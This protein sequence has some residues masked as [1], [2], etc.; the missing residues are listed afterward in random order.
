MFG[1]YD[2][3]VYIQSVSD[4]LVSTTLILLYSSIGGSLTSVGHVELDAGIMEGKTLEAGAV[5]CVKTVKNPVSLARQVME[6][7]DHV[8]LVAEGAEQFAKSISFAEVENS[9][10][11]SQK[12]LD[13]LERT[14]ARYKTTIQAN[15]SGGFFAD[16]TIGGVCTTGNGE[17]IAKMV[18]AHRISSKMDAGFSPKEA[19]DAALEEMRLRIDG[20]GYGGAIA[21]NKNGD[22]AY[23]FNTYRMSWAIRRRDEIRFGINRGEEIIERIG[24]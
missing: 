1:K 18:L 14:R 3:H 17:A 22:V 9:S 16:D 12:S 20:D 15:Y 11:I 6:K 21:V 5:G 4:V 13:A 19:C 2:M 7:T 24:D 8:F 10:L 23:S